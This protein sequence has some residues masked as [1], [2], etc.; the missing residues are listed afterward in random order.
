MHC[1][2]KYKTFTSLNSDNGRYVDEPKYFLREVNI[3]MHNYKIH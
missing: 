3:K 1:K 2:V